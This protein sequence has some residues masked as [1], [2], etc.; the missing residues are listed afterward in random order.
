MAELSKNFQSILLAELLSDKVF[1]SKWSKNITPENF[2]SEHR[3]IYEIIKEHSDKYSSMPEVMTIW[4][5]IKI[6]YPV[7]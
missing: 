5:Q 6:K 1:F 3:T 4:D 2:N 7:I